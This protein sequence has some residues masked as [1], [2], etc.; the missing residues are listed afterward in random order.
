MV[1]VASAR[2]RAAAAR[3]AAAFAPGGDR[4][5]YLQRHV[6]SDGVAWTRVLVGGF[7][8]LDAAATWARA[9][10]AAGTLAYAREAE[11]D[12]DALEP[13]ALGAERGDGRTAAVRQATDALRR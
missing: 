10:I 5:V 13:A 6:G 7:A 2:D 11:V 3:W 12:Q 9:R 4:G 1:H 8:S